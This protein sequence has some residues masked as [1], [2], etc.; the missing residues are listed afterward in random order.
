MRLPSP[1]TLLASA[2]HAVISEYRKLDAPP[3]EP[4]AA[5]PARQEINCTAASTQQ[6]WQPAHRAPAA[7]RAFGFGKQ[8][9]HG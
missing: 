4:P 6:A 2:V 9:G 3:P 8:S 1:A 5:G 7:A